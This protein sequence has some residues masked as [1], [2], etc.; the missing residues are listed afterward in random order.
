MHPPDE[1]RK[2]MADPRDIER[3]LRNPLVQALLH[4]LT[5]KRRGGSCLL[6]RIFAK[7]ADDDLSLIDRVRYALPFYLTD[8]IRTRAG[9]TVE[10]VRDG[11]FRHP[12]RARALINTARGVA[13]YGLTK[14]Q[15]FSAPLMVVWNFTQA[16]NLKCV[17]CYQDAHKR[18]PDE[19]TE[20]EQI[21][22]VDELAEN[23]V[24]LLAFSGGE[25][26]ISPSFWPVLSHAGKSDFHISVA[27][28]GTL[29]DEA[30]ACRL[31]DCGMNFIEISLDSVDAKKHDRFRGGTGNWQKA[32]DGIKAAVAAREKHGHTFG[33]S[34]ASTITQMNFDELEDLISLAK[35]LGCTSFYAFNFIPTGR[36]KSVIDM[37]LAPDQR[38]EM[39]RILYDHMCSRDINIITSAAQMSR[40]CVES[41]TLDGVFGTGHYGYGPGLNAMLLSQYIGGCGAGRC[42]CAVQPNG[43]VTP[44]VFMQLEVGDLRTHSLKHIWQHSPEMKL[45]RDREDRTGGCKTCDYKIY[46][47]GCRARAYGYYGDITRSDPGCSFNIQQWEEL[48]SS[49]VAAD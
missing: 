39:L 40:K 7:Y 5:R 8:L 28:N 36:A 44:C 49:A 45:L 1:T 26:M 17:H 32:V 18:L 27:T 37:D 48:T 42:Y 30:S 12:S 22:I 47:G 33:V 10:Q 19:L 2:T 21:R 46:C 23:D 9:A 20:N 24:P 38:E 34:L 29:L 43:K 3:V 4:V 35:D 15:V 6:E 16:C 41:S 31:G 25:P 14:P 13:E 11:V